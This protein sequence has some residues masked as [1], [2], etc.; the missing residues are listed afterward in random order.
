MACQDSQA[1]QVGKVIQDHQVCQ[2]SQGFLD[3][4]NQD[5]QDQRVIKVWVGHLDFLDQKEIRAT[6]DCLVCLD[7]LD[8]MVHQVPQALWEPQEV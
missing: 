5:F 8:Q 1:C 7:P 4:V 6:E 3:L 2:E